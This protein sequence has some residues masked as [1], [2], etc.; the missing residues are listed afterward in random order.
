MADSD[1]SILEDK[2]LFDK[3]HQAGLADKLTHSEEWR[4]LKEAAD[5]IIERALNRFAFAIRADDMVGVIETQILLRKYK[6]GLFQ[7][8]SQLAEE[9]KLYFDEFK[10]R[11]YTKV[12]EK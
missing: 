12:P 11:G 4:L 3:L 9:G 8:V 1:F 10:E 2:E 7:E 5:R 6:Y